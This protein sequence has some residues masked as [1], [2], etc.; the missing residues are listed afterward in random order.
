MDPIRLFAFADEASPM[1]NEQ[2]QAMKRNNLSGLEIRG[3]D[4]TSI[5]D[6]SLQKAKEVREKLTANGLVTWSIGSPIGKIHIRDPFAPHLELMKHTLEIANILGAENIRIFSFYMT[7]EDPLQQKNAVIDRLG[8][9]CELA[10]ANGIRPCHENEKGIFG[11]IPERCVEIHRHI[12][13]LRGIFDPA[14]YIQCGVDT[15]KA[16]TLLKDYIYYLHIKDAAPD[17]FVV[18]AGCGIG[19]IEAIVQDFIANG[20]R[21][22]T[23][24]PHLTVFSG[25]KGLELANQ[26]TQ[27]DHFRYPDAN[28][29]FDAACKAF[30]QL[31][32][33]SDCMSHQGGEI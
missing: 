21:N 25:L 9:L 18:P 2:I 4:G 3:V 19:H 20:G 8:A 27:I 12:P 23:I 6:I 30:Q 22:F 32:V 14:N 5:S 17:G 15:L 13:E 29:A 1:I 24:E 7:D 10:I 31:I 26:E 16:W 33:H 11:D 28:T